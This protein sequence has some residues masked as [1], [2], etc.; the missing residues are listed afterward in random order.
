ME[1][2]FIK[3]TIL[4]LLTLVVSCDNAEDIEEKKAIKQEVQ[5]TSKTI[6]SNSNGK[7]RWFS[8]AQKIQGNKVFSKNCASC[9]GAK[10]QGANNWQKRDLTGRFPA[11][12]LDGTAHSWHH[13]QKQLLSVINKGSISSGGIM[14]SFKDSLTEEE[15][16]S[17]LA[18]FEAKWS[19]EI[20]QNWIKRGGLK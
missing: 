12:P 11:P 15:R 1:N 2:K 3:V 16:L 7:D 9:H 20:Y 6:K 13:T 18:F 4:S 17:V 19:N 8:F 10:A 14:P 5:K